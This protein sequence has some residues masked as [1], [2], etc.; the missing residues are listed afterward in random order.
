MDP[1]PIALTTAAVGCAVVGVV[2]LAWRRSA[3]RRAELDAALVRSRDEVQTL[4]RR[5]EELADEVSRAGAAGERDRG[6]VIT[7]MGDQV[8]V[9]P[10]GDVQELVVPA[11]RAGLT[12]RL[13]QRLLAAAAQGAA[14]APQHART[15]QLTVRVLALAHG[16]RRALSPDVLDR[17]AAEAH[18]ARRRS[19]R[20][21]RR[22]LRSRQ[23]GR[24][25]AA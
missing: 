23:A 3:R 9:P 8:A 15:V 10:G 19:R 22:Q 25:Q 11:A 5:V 2:V 17:A 12:T 13:E 4:C 1:V 14:G 18:V 7:S 20:A 21:R 24:G 6:Y 16:V